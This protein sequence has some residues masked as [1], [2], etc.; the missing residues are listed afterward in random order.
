MPIR[1]LLFCLL[2]AIWL[3]L[4]AASAPLTRVIGLVPVLGAVLTFY[5]L[6]AGI[7][8]YSRKQAKMRHAP[9]GEIFRHG[10]LFLLLSVLPIVWAFIIAAP[11]P[12]AEVFFQNLTINGRSAHLILDTG[13]SFADLGGTGANRLGI[14]PAVLKPG[15]SPLEMK[16]GAGVWIWSDPLRL[17][18]GN[19]TF[20][21]ALPIATESAELARINFHE[22]D[23]GCIGWPEGCWSRPATPTDFTGC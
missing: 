7:V 20:T 10:A 9:R 8:A 22:G 1:R 15:E 11:K 14:K 18:H 21:F 16:A 5:I 19:Q 13:S 6:I 17:T 12:R 4:M 2:I 23:E 3:V